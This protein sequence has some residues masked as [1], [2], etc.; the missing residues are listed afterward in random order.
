MAGTQFKVSL[1]NV[2]IFWGSVHNA[3]LPEGL[4]GKNAKR[5]RPKSRQENYE[6]YE[7]FPRKNQERKN[8]GI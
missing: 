4:D 1:K 2:F 5:T 6:L 3:H 7:H 8:P